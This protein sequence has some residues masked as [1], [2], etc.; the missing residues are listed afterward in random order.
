MSRT[1]AAVLTELYR[2]Y[3]HTVLRRAERILGTRAEA[4]D[5]LHDLFVRWHERPEELERMREP[6]AFVYG[7]TTHACLNRLRNAKT[8]ARLVQREVP[9]ESARPAGET[10]VL[11]KEALMRLP[12]ELQDIAIYYHLDRMTQEEIAQVVGCSRRTVSDRV[13]KVQRLTSGA[14]EEVRP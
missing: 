2:G 12:D 5:V 14:H 9:R 6:A 10:H 4:E 7:A 8:R 3:A 13:A 11:L 1:H